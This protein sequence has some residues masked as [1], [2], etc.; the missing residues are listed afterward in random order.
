MSMN[1]KN[2]RTMKNKSIIA[3]LAAAFT[4][5]LTTSCEDMLNVESNRVVYEEEHTLSSTADSVYTTNGILQSFQQLADRYILLGELRGDL[6]DVNDITQTSL[7]QIANFEIGEDNEYADPTPYYAVINNCNYLLARMDTTY[8]KNGKPLML[9]EYAGALSIRAW[10]YMQ[11]AINYGRVPF[12]TEPLTNV[13]AAEDVLSN[14]SRWLDIKEIAA[15]LIPELEAFVDVKMPV[16]TSPN[17]QEVQF[18]FPPIRLVLGDLYLWSEDYYNAS[19]YILDYLVNRTNNKL[20]NFTF[21]GH[22][23]EGYMLNR[24]Q[25]LSYNVRDDA[26]GTGGIHKYRLE[27]QNVAAS[28]WQS[29]TDVR[30]GKDKPENLCSIMLSTSKDN[31]TV[32][33][34]NNLFYSKN[35]THQIVPSELWKQLNQQQNY[36]YKMPNADKT[37]E[38]YFEFV[39]GGDAR[40]GYYYGDKK[41]SYTIN[42]KE[43][44]PITKFNPLKSDD[45]YVPIN[46]YRRSVAYLR[47]AEA[48]NSYAAEEYELG[49]SISK[50]H[51]AEHAKMAFNL[52][53]DAYSAFLAINEHKLDSTYANAPEYMLKV[54]KDTAELREQRIDLQ[55]NYF[56]GVHARGCGDVH[57][58]T[59]TYTLK[60]AAIANYF[61]VSSGIHLLAG[62]LTFADTIK[63]VEERILDELALEAAFEGNRFGDLIRFAERRGEPELLINRVANR[64]GI[65]DQKLSGIL[66]DKGNWYIDLPEYKMK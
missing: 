23:Y 43:Y 21:N 13:G 6:V 18:A 25:K 7:R 57:L 58:D 63:Y 2:N 60:P 66:Q 17:T 47:A 32:S 26:T 3:L 36:I 24:G 37:K 54:N 29:Y 35:G 15:E 39:A 10:T 48:L 42:N 33:D 61:K 22:E 46:L 65:V 28:N 40:G 30:A 8:K 64:S 50:A 53:K 12:Y 34:V 19:Y 56:Q 4:L 27:T 62:M 44:Q 1:K 38:D 55:S 59:L 20:E 16:W 52:L 51:A 5:T 49:D 41:N 11:L 45:K 9:D 14:Q 31:G